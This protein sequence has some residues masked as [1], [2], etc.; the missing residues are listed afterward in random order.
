MYCDDID[1]FII[2]NKSKYSEE[3]KEYFLEKKK[4]CDNI[5]NY[6]QFEK[7]I[8]SNA[9][10]VFLKRYGNF[11]R[12]Y[13]YITITD[14]DYYIYDMKSTVQEIIAAFNNSSCAISSADLYLGNQLNNPNKV[15]GAEHYIDFM[16]KRENVEL[17]NVIGIG[18]PS[19]MTLQK[20]DLNILESVYYLDGNIRSKVSEIGKNW[21]I[22]TK[23]LSYCLTCD[24]SYPGNEYF[25]WK[26][27]YGYA[28]WH[29]TEESDYK[30]II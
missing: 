26:R 9:I 30:I 29:I 15:I 28:I 17:K 25:D 2:E 7:N 14:G 12:N 24:I 3:I 16:K 10:N 6:I 1:Y 21:Y 5:I 23:N 4:T 22:T 20:K 27:N 13:E 18:I 11:L 19:L 8:S